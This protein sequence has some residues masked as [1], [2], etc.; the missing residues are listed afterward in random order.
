[1]SKN[2]WVLLE[3][4]D[5][6]VKKPCLETVA[7]AKKVAATCGGKVCAL[8]LGQGIRGRQGGGGCKGVC[9]RIG[10]A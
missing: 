8:L 2:I 9:R 10:L 7:V 1:M 4:R 3:H 6:K 5:G